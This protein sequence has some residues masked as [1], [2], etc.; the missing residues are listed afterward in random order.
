MYVCIAQRLTSCVG[1]YRNYKHIYVVALW[2]RDYKQVHMRHSTT[3]MQ[4]INLYKHS[5]RASIACSLC[6]PIVLRLFTKFL[7]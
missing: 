5:T 7:L 3:N 4:I 2:S 6:R 1:S